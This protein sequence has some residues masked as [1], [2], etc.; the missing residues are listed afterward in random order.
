[1]H[2]LGINFYDAE[3][4]KDALVYL[5]KSF[6]LMESL[7]DA[8]KLRHL[9]TVQDLY[10]HIAIILSDRGGV[11]DED[12]KKKNEEALQYLLKAKEIYEIVKEHT[13]DLP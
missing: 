13:Q 4:S 7:P 12:D 2:L 3:E 9:N 10:N 8:L 6:E 5:Q 11:S 1:M